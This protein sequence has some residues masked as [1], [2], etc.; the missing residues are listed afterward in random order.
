M[1]APASTLYSALIAGGI[2][3]GATARDIDW[4]RRNH[5]FYADHATEP[6]AVAWRRRQA[7]LCSEVLTAI[8]ETAA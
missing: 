7:F 6:R 1:T 2:P 3:A 5:E 8:R 4:L